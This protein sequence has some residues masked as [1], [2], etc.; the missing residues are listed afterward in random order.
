MKHFIFYIILLCSLALFSQAEEEL[1]QYDNDKIQQKEFNQKQIESYKANDDFIYI[2]EKREATWLE[3]LWNWIKRKVKSILSFLFD[4]IAPAV[5]FLKA[6]L[7]ALPYVIAGLVLYFIIKFFL[8]VNARNIIGGKKAQSIVK[9]TEEEELIHEKDLPQL[10]NNAI[11]NGN[12]RLA[13][14]Y[15]YLLILKKLSE[16]ELIKWQ[17][18]KTNEDYIKE[19]SKNKELNTDF[20]EV[21]LLYDY[22]WYG[23][24]PIDKTVFLQAEKQLKQFISAV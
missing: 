19:V 9:L 4:D 20:K 8:K 7:K 15:Y 17:Q 12:Y 1:V 3:N 21:T 5:G 23:D 13:V 24:F 6:I 22:V 14:R 16:K 2:I 11:T 10:I 18:E